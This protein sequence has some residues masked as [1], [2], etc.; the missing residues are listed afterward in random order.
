ME[1]HS[2]KRLILYFD[3]TRND[4]GTDTNILRLYNAT[5]QG[6]GSDGVEQECGYWKGV[7]VNLGEMILGG[8]FGWGMSENI[9]KG[10]HWIAECYETGDEVC[11]FGFSR[12]A[13]T[14]M[15]LL[16]LLAWRGLPKNRVQLDSK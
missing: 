5:V 13:F 16:G 15:G 12:G 3:G 9:K 11:I 14:A 2:K 8:G 1:S 7:G 4:G 10:Y 6:K